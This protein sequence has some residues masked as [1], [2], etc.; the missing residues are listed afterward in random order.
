MNQQKIGEFLKYLR[1]NKGLT[2]EQLAEHFCVSSR[3]V[4][5]WE[6]GN[7]MPDISIL[8]DIADYYDISI[9]EIISGER[10]SENMDKKTK[11]TVIKAAE[12]MNMG[13]EQYTKRVRLLLQTGAVF[14]FVASLIS[15]TELSNNTVLNAVS[16]FTEGAA[17]GMILCGIIFTSRYGHRIRAFKE[18][19]FK[20]H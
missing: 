12:Y 7:N 6:N 13:T 4:S 19:L 15:H 16:E 2:Q 11:E 8:V 18:R 1:K 10:Q 14:W 3:T 5:R 17:I 20:R 9:P